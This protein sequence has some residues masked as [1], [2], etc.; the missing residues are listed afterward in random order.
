MEEKDFCTNLQNLVHPAR[1]GLLPLPPPHVKG[2]GGNRRDVHSFVE[3]YKI[4]TLLL[5]VSFCRKIIA[6]THLT[7]ADIKGKVGDVLAFYVESGFL[8]I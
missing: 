2:E 6:P 7:S 1:R 3:L 8:G 5:T 4:P